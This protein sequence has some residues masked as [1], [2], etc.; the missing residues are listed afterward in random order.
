MKEYCSSISAI[1][2]LSCTSYLNLIH[3]L[4][5]CIP[6]DSIGCFLFSFL[7]AGIHPAMLSCNIYFF[8]SQLHN[9]QVTT[10]F[11]ASAHSTSF[12]TSSTPPSSHPRPSPLPLSSISLPRSKVTHACTV[13]TLSKLHGKMWLKVNKR[14]RVKVE[15]FMVLNKGAVLSP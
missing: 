3:L 5:V 15:A 14:Y 13:L 2:S 10:T 11:S 12:S 6:S 7:S 1:R 8:F 9:T 4:C